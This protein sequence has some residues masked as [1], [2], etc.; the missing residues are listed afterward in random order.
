MILTLLCQMNVN[1]TSLEMSKRQFIFKELSAIPPYALR[2]GSR[3]SLRTVHRDLIH[4]GLIGKRAVS[5]LQVEGFSAA[6]ELLG[7]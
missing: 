1:I 4:S 2:V 5:D 3:W 6:R 7:M